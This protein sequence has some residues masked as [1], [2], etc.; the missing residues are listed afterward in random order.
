VETTVA[1]STRAISSLGSIPLVDVLDEVRRETTALALLVDRAGAVWPKVSAALRATCDDVEHRV[2]RVGVV[3]FLVGTS[4]A[5]RR[6]VNA[7]LREDVF[8]VA[9]GEG[10]APVRITVRRG[11]ARTYTAETSSGPRAFERDRSLD[12]AA[13]AALAEQAIPRALAFVAE[14]R[15]LRSKTESSPT[16]VP[17]APSSTRAVVVPTEDSTPDLLVEPR[18]HPPLSW[19]ARALFVILA[20]FGHRTARARLAPP[21][22]PSTRLAPAPWPELAAEERPPT[23]SELPPERPVSIDERVAIE[24]RLL[25]A[26]AAVTRARAEAERARATHAS[27]A[28]ERHE[29]F[30]AELAALLAEPSGVV[31]I[32]LEHPSPMLPSDVVLLDERIVEDE[33]PRAWR[34]V[35]R[36]V[37]ACVVATSGS[38]SGELARLA[39]ENLRPLSPLVVDASASGLRGELSLTHVVDAVRR[40]A[41]P[42]IAALAI[43]DVLVVLRSL[44]EASDR[45]EAECKARIA[46][47][48][49]RRTPEPATFRQE[50]LDAL[51]PVVTEAAGRVM[52]AALDRWR[53]SVAE[54]R[55][56]WIASVEAA[57]DRASVEAVVKAVD[58]EAPRRLASAVETLTS[59]VSEDMQRTTSTL[60]GWMLDEF[61]VRFKSL[62]NA[63]DPAVVLVDDVAEEVPS[64][65]ELPLG[66]VV[67]SFE[68]RRVGIGLGGA[69]AGAA[70]GTLIFPGIGTAVGAFVGVLAGFIET[71]AKLKRDAVERLGAHLDAVEAQVTK[72]LEGGLDAFAREMTASLVETLDQELTRRAPT[73]ARMMERERA[74]LV[75]EEAKLVEVADVRTGLVRHRARFAGLEK[76]VTDALDR[77][78]EAR[79]S[80]V[81]PSPSLLE[82][83]RA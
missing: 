58:E 75:R 16:P 32:D 21:A 38:D 19:I 4:A 81:T 63:P 83:E 9:F 72:Q 31:S 10:D 11:V 46:D 8:P 80:R 43:G 44:A 35:R 62:S 39:G 27:Y 1:A 66:K 59:S 18:P 54:L 17:A 77:A 40:E 12:L 57:S 25:E 78:V 42:S 47:I 50:Q 20:F 52:R 45:A 7:L 2:T 29:R 74:A 41:R 69:A 64:V 23:P 82:T 3:V 22:P 70:L 65:R 34:R 6:F 68:R 71:L 49:K 73:I 36:Q 53:G 60:Q 24:M 55:A 15:D 37:G 30:R 5:K 76:D 14:L 48:E 79:I 33:G 61:S 13:E 67:D 26:E 51:R 56:V 28:A